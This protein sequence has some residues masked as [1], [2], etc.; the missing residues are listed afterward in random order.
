QAWIK[1]VKHHRSGGLAGARFNYC[2]MSAG[3]SS[4]AQRIMGWADTVAS[5]AEITLVVR[6]L[7]ADLTMLRLRRY[8]SSLGFDQSYDYLYLPRCLRTHR[9]KG[10]AF[11]NLVSP[12]VA[13]SFISSLSSQL[14]GGHALKFSIADTQGLAKNILKWYRGHSR[15]VRDPEVLPFIRPLRALGLSSPAQLLQLAGPA[16]DELP[17]PPPPR[18][19]EPAPGSGGLGLLGGVRV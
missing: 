9:C 2:V 5:P 6:G 17:A 15:H 1:P 19:A 18:G 16:G 4:T 8:I 7:P 13:Q 11:T 14:I 12:E 10:Y 3:S